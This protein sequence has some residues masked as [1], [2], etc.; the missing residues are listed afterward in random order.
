METAPQL[1]RVLRA[2]RRRLGAAMFLRHAARATLF[3][4]AIL[5]V[6]RAVLWWHGT[7]R[8]DPASLPYMLSWPFILGMIGGAILAALRFPSLALT[9]AILDARGNTRDR[10][11]SA[12]E[13]ATRKDPTEMQR[14]AVRDTTDWLA[15][16]DLRPLAPIRFP[17]E[18]RFVFVPLATLALLWWHELERAAQ[19][20]AAIAVA[21]ENASTTVRSLEA[22]AEQL[23]ERSKATDD[24][25]LQR[26][27]ERLQ[28]SAAQVRAE[29]NRAGDTNTA[30]LRQ[31]AD[32][33]QLV[34]ELRQPQRATPD[35]LKALSGALAQNEPTKAAAKH[36]EENRF[37]EAARE[38]EQLESDP[39]AAKVE[40][41]LKQ[42]VEHLAQRKE[43]VSKQLQQLG[44]GL[45]QPGGERPQ[46]LQQIAQ[47]LRDL[48]GRD[49]KNKPQ[50]GRQQA[51]NQQQE[52]GG[53]E[54]TDQDLKKLLSALQE[55]KDKQQE[56]GEENSNGGPGKESGEG[57]GPITMLSFEPAQKGD[58]A[59]ELGIPSGKPGSE[60]DNGTTKDPFAEQ[61]APA[62]ASE[63]PE[64]L[65]GELS[66]G[67]SLSLLVPSA[68][69]GDA[70]AVRRY[71]E[72]TEAAAAAAE[73]AVL[74]E[75]IPLGSRFL[76]KR[77][78]NAIRPRE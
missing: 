63:R 59:G 20:D 4:F 1:D 5:V 57:S 47:M 50:H 14:L 7:A 54:M 51:G 64:Q 3:F 46:L 8:P 44:E 43:Q 78:F 19:Q 38:L 34:K 28:Q 36:M 58:P 73:D 10:L 42:A 55:L 13:F 24:K 49:E 52:K 33:E 67:E 60:K 72:L 45:Q 62:G 12:R 74:Q 18:L 23:R 40:A 69:A 61:S 6:L 75:H 27:A 11:V 22:L 30:A 68:S 16:Q 76:I 53:Q 77:Y 56:G 39:E 29:A 35:E 70:K 41:A 65:K 25:T 9:A 31:I 71:K 66:E 2:M 15:R 17:R 32:L 21:R 26:V 48:P 37:N